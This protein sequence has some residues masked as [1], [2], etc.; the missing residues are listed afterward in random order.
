MKF[1]TGDIVEEIFKKVNTDK[2]PFKINPEKLLHIIHNPLEK[3]KVRE[4]VI[5][6][7]SS[8]FFIRKIHEALQ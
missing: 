2:L 1:R 4:S 6:R 8:D 3:N 5:N 7:F